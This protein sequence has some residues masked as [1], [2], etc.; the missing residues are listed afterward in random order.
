MNK[1][2]FVLFV[3]VFVSLL[4]LGSCSKSK[5]PVS[6]KSETTNDPTGNAPIETTVDPNQ[7]KPPTP[8]IGEKAATDPA[9]IV[10][11][12]YYYAIKAKDYEKAYSLITGEFKKR[13]GTFTEFVAP[14]SQAA[15]EGRIY[16]KVT[17]LAVT[18]S[19][20][21]QE[22]IVTFTLSIFEKQNPIE[23]N[24]AYFLFLQE[25]GTWKI[26]DTISQP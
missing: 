14:L 13:K 9:S 12:D 26:A 25:D 19:Q 21:G 2:W 18:E 4:V 24:G 5:K 16:D 1:R 11:R 3:C 20:S 7:F 15:D 6:G 23:L 22:K 8:S 10:V 17:I